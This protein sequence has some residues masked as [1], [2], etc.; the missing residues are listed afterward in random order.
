MNKAHQLS[1]RKDEIADFLRMLPDE[2]I[3]ISGDHEANELFI[4]SN[5]INLAKSLKVRNHS[6]TGFNWGYGGSGPAQTALAILLHYVD[7]K[8][9]QQYYQDF[10]F[11]WVA[12]LPQSN[13]T[14]TINLREVMAE[15]LFK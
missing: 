15:I 8:T 12:G 6:P 14:K 13:F 10:K 4:N 11:G 7:A 9:A 2:P 3:V 5:K 1:D